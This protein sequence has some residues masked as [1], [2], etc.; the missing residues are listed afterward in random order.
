[1]SRNKNRNKFKRHEGHLVPK[2]TTKPVEA[3]AGKWVDVPKG[4]VAAPGT[5][6]DADGVMRA[7]GTNA[8]VVWHNGPW[9]R[10]GK[11]TKGRIV[12]EEIIYDP[13]TNAPWCPVCWVRECELRI[14]DTAKKLHDMFSTPEERNQ[15]YG[16]PGTGLFQQKPYRPTRQ[17]IAQVPPAFQSSRGRQAREMGRRLGGP[18]P[19]ELGLPQQHTIAVKT[20]EM[21]C[22]RGGQ[23]WGHD[24][25]C[26]TLP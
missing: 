4:M 7:V 6:I 14:G 17:P 23:Q 15:S 21:N 13:V 24:P 26:P 2:D 22:C 5:Y 16:G 20:N 25:H 8:C 12:P 18:S 1:M 19:F 3:P 10:D 11:C 9:R